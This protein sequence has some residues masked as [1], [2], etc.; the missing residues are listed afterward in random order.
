MKIFLLEGCLSNLEIKLIKEGFE[1]E[2]SFNLFLGLKSCL[3]MPFKGFQ[4][5]GLLFS[6]SLGLKSY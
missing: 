3:K 2:I 1:K 6:T 5:L 4:K